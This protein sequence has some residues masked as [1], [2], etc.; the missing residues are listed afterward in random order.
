MEAQMIP[1][2]DLQQPIRALHIGG[3][4]GLRIRDRIVVMRFRGKMHDGVMPRREAV[5]QIGVADIAMR[6]AHAIRRQPGYIRRIAR[7]GQRIQHRHPHAG[8]LAH[9]MA[10]EIRPDEPASAGH[11]DVARIECDVA[12]TFSHTRQRSA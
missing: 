4:K 11:D 12:Y 7:I 6:Q 1:A 8:M 2:R 3:D 9:H 10:H 5:Q